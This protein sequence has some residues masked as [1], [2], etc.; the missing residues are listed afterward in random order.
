[1]VFHHKFEDWLKIKGYDLNQVKEMDSESEE[2]KEILQKSPYHKATSADVDWIE[3]VRMQG[4]IQEWVDHSI[5]VTIN[6]PEDASEELVGQAYMEA[7]KSG[8]KGMTI[9]REGSRDSIMK[10][11]KSKLEE[12]VLVQNNVAQD[13]RI[14]IKPQSIKYKVKRQNNGDSLHFILTSDLYVDEKNKK[15]YF[16]PDED[17]QIRAPNGAATSVSFSQAGMDRTEILRS[18]N[19]DYAELVKRWQSPFSNED[20]G[21]GPMRIKSIEHAAGLVFEHYLTANGVIGRDENTGDL[22]N[23]V[24]K[25]D[26][27][28]VDK[29][30]EEYKSLMSQIRELSSE[31]ENNKNGNNRKINVKFVCD[32]CGCE[33]TVFKDGCSS[34]ACKN[35]G[36]DN[37]KGCG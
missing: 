33:E 17:F 18:P 16:I 23:K 37:G 3:K 27:K 15:A 28:M 2:F 6:L 10:S 8:C 24:R 36:H 32:I 31:K 26:L 14:D 21:I 5:S 20:E 7:W 30:S 12:I 4:K 1:M 19:P 11:K 29:N 35:C 25:A 9:Y 13:K 34:P 22:V